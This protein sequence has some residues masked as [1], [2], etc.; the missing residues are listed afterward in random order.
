[1]SC[2]LNPD[3][4]LKDASDIKFYNDPDDNIPLPNVP[5]SSNTFPVLLK[6]GCTPAI[7]VAGSRRSG[8]PSKPSARIRDADNACG[9]SASGS[10]TRKCALS[11]TTDP[12]VPIKKATMR[13]LSPP[14]T[15]DEDIPSPLDPASSDELIPQPDEDEDTD[16]V[17]FENGG[18]TQTV[19]KSERTADIWT[20]FSH[21]PDGW[22]CTLCKDAGEPAHKNMFHGGTSTLRTHI[23]CYKR[24]HFRVYKECCDAAAITMHSHAILPGEDLTATQQTLDGSLVS[25]LAV[26][27]KEGLMEYIMEL[28]MTEDEA[29]QL[30]DKPAFRCLLLYARSSLSEKDIPHRTKLTDTIKSRAISIVKRIKEHLALAA[31]ES[32]PEAA[33]EDGFNVADA[34]GKALALIEQICKSPQ[35]RAF[36][37]KSCEEEG[38]P[39]RELLAWVRTCWASLFKSLERFLSLRLAVNHFTLL[40]DDSHKVPMLRNKLYGDFKLDQADWKKLRLV[41]NVLKEPATAQQSFSSATHPTAW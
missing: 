39:I 27:M 1:M 13:I 32:D 6:A 38:I 40:A 29:I 10:S 28:I 25:K 9:L 33:T 19:T 11:S 2:A 37:Q 5:S 4:S 41:H 24:T 14:D 34:V 3:G 17:K 22:V 20:I 15:D 26:F 7:V 18:A 30:V 16:E 31:L 35:A 23:V 36:F 12:P 21:I 8:R